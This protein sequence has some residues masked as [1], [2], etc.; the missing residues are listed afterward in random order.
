MAMECWEPGELSNPSLLFGWPPLESALA[1]VDVD[2]LASLWRL[3]MSGCL[4][5]LPP[6]IV[7]IF[8][9]IFY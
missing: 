5:F 7:F 8:I 1:L 3:R 6:A 2:I 9:F 4:S